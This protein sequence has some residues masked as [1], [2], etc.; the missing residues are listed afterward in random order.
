MV[1][2][3]RLK[4]VAD[5]SRIHAADRP[6]AV[7]LDYNDRITTY[8]ELDVRASQVAQG[9]IALGQKPGARVGYLGKNVDRYFEVLL[10]TFKARAVTVGV[11]WRLAPPEIA[12]VLNDAGCEVLFVAKEF[13]GA[14]D[15]IRGDC[16]KLKT[17]IAMDGGHAGW[18]SYEDWRDEQKTADPDAAGRARRRRDPALHLR[19]NGPSQRRA[20]DERKLS[21][22]HPRGG[23]DG[24][25]RLH[26]GRRRSHRHAVLPRRRRE[27]RSF[28]ADAGFARHRAR[29]YRSAD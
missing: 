9:L 22:D 5:I 8:G 15:K 13:Y 1:D 25:R 14:I 23:R 16:P 6:N 11:N 26:A 29:R 7:A 10:G 2:F 3:T 18:P 12:Y 28:L 20:A 27:H 17:V 4:S 19:H 21:R 24:R